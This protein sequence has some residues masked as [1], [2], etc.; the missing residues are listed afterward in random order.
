[1]LIPWPINHVPVIIRK[2]IIPCQD[3]VYLY[4]TVITNNK[5]TAL[6]SNEPFTTGDEEEIGTHAEEGDVFGVSRGK[7]I[8]LSTLDRPRLLWPWPLGWWCILYNAGHHKFNIAPKTRCLC[9]FNHSPVFVVDY[10]DFIPCATDA[11]RLND[12]HPDTPLI[13]WLSSALIQCC[14]KADLAK[15][16]PESQN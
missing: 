4:R 9:S 12:Y 11:R 3:M 6:P 15:Y 5:A 10:D 8:H 7:L 13:Y 1:M 2:V 14:Q 16:C